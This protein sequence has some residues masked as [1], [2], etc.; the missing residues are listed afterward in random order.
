VSAPFDRALRR[1]L[2]SADATVFVSE[3]LRQQALELGAAHARTRVI[4]KGVDLLRFQPAVDKPLLRREL[5]V[6]DDPLI[7]AVAGLI[8]IKGIRHIF[9]ALARIRDVHPFSFVLCGEGPEL[10]A[11][12]SLAENLAVLNQTRF[13]GRIARSDIAKY[14]GAADLFVHGG[15]IE[16][17]GNALLEAMAAGLP[18]V[19]TDSGGP[20]EYVLDGSAGFV[21]PVAN[22]EA[23]AGKILLLL[24]DSRLRDV[25]GRQARHRAET[26]FG[27]DRMIRDTLGVYQDLTTPVSRARLEVTA[28]TEAKRPPLLAP[29]NIRNA[30]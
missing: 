14:F 30:E 29:N 5:G 13:V 22:A 6:G 11:L 17:S 15:L 10:D 26:L 20:R 7:L 24:R 3:F 16:A 19:C 2:R 8:P 18:V 21:V 1:L 9:A 28:P 4:L 23:M 27:Y 25:L 12:R